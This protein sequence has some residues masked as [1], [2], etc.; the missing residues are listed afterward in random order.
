MFLI[1]CTFFVLSLI[2]DQ[3]KNKMSSL[4]LPLSFHPHPQPFCRQSKLTHSQ[5][6]LYTNTGKKWIDKKKIRL[7][8]FVLVQYFELSYLIRQI[9]NIVQGLYNQRNRAR[10]EYVRSSL[11]CWF[12][13]FDYFQWKCPK[14]QSSLQCYA[15]GRKY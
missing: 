7:V 3:L 1:R 15:G 10:S 5:G 8:R 9:Q 11:L 14:S 13:K 4:T 2:N 6:S 12:F